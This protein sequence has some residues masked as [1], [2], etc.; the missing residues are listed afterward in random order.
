VAANVTAL[1]WSPDGKRLAVHDDK[2]G[3]TLV[4]DTATNRGMVV[5]AIGP[6]D[7]F[8]GWQP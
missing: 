2:A 5:F 6:D 3:Q 4:L 7:A 1:A 8:F